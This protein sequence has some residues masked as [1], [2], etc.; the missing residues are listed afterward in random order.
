MDATTY[1]EHEGF[2]LLVLAILAYSLPDPWGYRLVVI[3]MVGYVATHPASVRAIE[4]GF[5]WIESRIIF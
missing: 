3:I 4:Q 2:A 1:L 5:N